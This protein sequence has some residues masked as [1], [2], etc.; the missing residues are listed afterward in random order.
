MKELSFD[1]SFLNFS[2]F[3]TIFIYTNLNIKDYEYS[4]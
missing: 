1:G 3:Y 4:C 2:K